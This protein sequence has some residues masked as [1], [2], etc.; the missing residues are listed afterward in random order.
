VDPSVN[1]ITGSNAE[2]RSLGAV[3]TVRAG[4]GF[5]SAIQESPHGKV[6]AA[7]L[8]DVQYGKLDWTDAIRTTLPR[9]PKEEELLRSGDILFSFRGTRYLAV[10]I[11]AV[12][13]SAVA[14]T[15]FMLV[16]VSDPGALLPEFLAWQ[17]NQPPA[18]RYFKSKATGTAQL[19]L[20]RGDIESVLVAI[21][22]MDFQK[23]VVELV[24]LVRLERQHL[25]RLL[26]N[27]E[28]QLNEIA[29][30]LFDNSERDAEA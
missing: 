28:H 21:P 13:G 30:S 6:I 25:E 19:S 8:R 17:L 7:Q 12:P 23:K 14:S 9:D 20:R 1:S 11:E 2:L 15:Q 16:R 18:Q 5:R 27:R 22:S 24:E 29:A 4:Y 26:H 3:A 10:A